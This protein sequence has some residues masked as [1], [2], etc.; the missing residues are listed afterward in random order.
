MLRTKDTHDRFAT[1][2]STPTPEVTPERYGALLKR[3]HE[4]Y[5]QLLDE[6][7]LKPKT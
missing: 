2:G 5:R 6:L 1:Q 3:E 4:T 7:G